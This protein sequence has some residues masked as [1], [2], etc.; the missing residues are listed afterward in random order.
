M[1]AKNVSYQAKTKRDLVGEL[2]ALEYSLGVWKE[3][4]HHMFLS[5]SPLLLPYNSLF[6]CET[7]NIYSIFFLPL[8]NSF[9]LSYPFVV[10]NMAH[11]WSEPRRKRKFNPIYE[12]G[13]RFYVP[14]HTPTKSV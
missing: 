9:S 8:I 3:R 10:T 12:I 4:E 13:F 5:K 2:D 14:K 11:P 1:Y 7:I 6:K